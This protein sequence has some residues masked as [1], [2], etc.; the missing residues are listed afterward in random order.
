MGFW[1]ELEQYRKEELVHRLPDGTPVQL[2]P[3]E[4]MQIIP[5]LGVSPARLEEYFRRHEG[6]AAEAADDPEAVAVGVRFQE[7]YW[8]LGIAAVA[9]RP[10]RLRFDHEEGDGLTIAE[11]KAFLTRKYGANA[12]REL[13]R[14]IYR[15]SGHILPEEVEQKPESFQAVAQDAAL[16]REDVR[17]VTDGD[18]APSAG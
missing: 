2:R 12:V 7:A 5:R 3:V 14:A 17:D 1:D 4:T 9:G 13:E 11:F 18:P 15:A 16:H 10:V 8:A 6:G